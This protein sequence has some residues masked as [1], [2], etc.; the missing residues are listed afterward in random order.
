MGQKA[1][2][3]REQKR[4]ETEEAR[5]KADLAVK[6][7]FLLGGKAKKSTHDPRSEKAKATT[8]DIPFITGAADPEAAR[9][10]S[11]KL[12]EVQKVIKQQT[13]QLK[14]DQSWVTPQLMQALSA[15]PDIA[16]AMSNPKIQEAMQLMQTDPE[17]AKNKYKDD[18]EVT[19]FFKDFTG[20]MATH[21]DVLSKEAPN[22][23]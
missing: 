12:P 22:P 14:E 6:K 4:K 9:R 8:E 23:P 13:Q 19:K 15:R 7:G 2:A 1:L 17:G 20:L 3:A 11:L 21:F 16:K 18:P 10:E 5:R